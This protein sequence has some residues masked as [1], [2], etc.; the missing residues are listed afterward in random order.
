MF[1]KT[2]FYTTILLCQQVCC[3]KICLESKR[4][5]NSKIAIDY[6]LVQFHADRFQIQGETGLG[7]TIGRSWGNA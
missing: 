7:G 3:V 4:V 6:L 1:L 2:D 5:S